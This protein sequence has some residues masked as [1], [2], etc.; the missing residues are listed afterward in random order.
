MD[1]FFPILFFATLSPRE[2]GLESAHFYSFQLD[3]LLKDVCIDQ[4]EPRFSSRTVI[5]AQARI[6]QKEHSA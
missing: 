4:L 1:D 3:P 2:W 5:L 6:Q